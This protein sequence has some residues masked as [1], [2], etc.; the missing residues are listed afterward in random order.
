LS[1]LK[2][3]FAAVLLICCAGRELPADPAPTIST[4][5]AILAGARAEAEKE[6]PY[7]MEYEVLKFPNGD[8]TPGTG[9]CTDLV[10][11][12]F[13]NAGIDLQAE[14]S[15]DRVSR[16]SAYPKLWDNHKPDRNID[17]RRCPNLVVWLKKNAEQLTTNIDAENLK[18]EWHAGDV[19]FYVRD[20]ATHPWHVGIVSNK[21]DKDGMPMIIDSFPPHT[22]ESHRLDAFGKIHSHF[23][24][25]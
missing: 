7:I 11:R 17:H 9:V 20:G 19:V 6:T 2:F 10:V 16:P 4:A 21:L 12:A 18:S 22:S 5:E 23:S 15:K 13:R 24:L 25:R 14:I 3:F 8:V 1:N